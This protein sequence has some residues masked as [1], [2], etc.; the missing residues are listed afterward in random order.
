M[1]AAEEQRRRELETRPE[2]ERHRQRLRQRQELPPDTNKLRF[3]ESGTEVSGRPPN[4]MA[5][6]QV[7]T[8]LLVDIASLFRQ[9]AFQLARRAGFT[10]SQLSKKCSSPRIRDADWLL[11]PVSQELSECP[12]AGP[13]GFG[14]IVVMNKNEPARVNAGIEKLQSR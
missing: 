12:G 4:S 11:W 1:A 3:S 8:P 14:T 7:L 10:A 5:D 6:E 9:P 13:V 2:A